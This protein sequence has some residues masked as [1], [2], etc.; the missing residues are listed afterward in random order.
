MVRLRALVADDDANLLEIVTSIINRFGLDVVAASCGA[1]LLEILAHGGP[2]DV[3]VTDVA[4]PW[5]TGL[6]VM[7]SAR[8]AGLSCPVIIMTALRDHETDRQVAGLGEHVLMLRK[9]FSVVELHAALS[10]S[11]AAVNDGVSP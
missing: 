1:S 11:V 9:P 3:I 4:M 6:H 5:I 8:A 2:F 7:H 10:E